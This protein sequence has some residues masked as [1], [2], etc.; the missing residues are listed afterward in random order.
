[1]SYEHEN[2]CRSGRPRTSGPA[3]VRRDVVEAEE[4]EDVLLRLEGGVHRHLGGA[5][6]D[7]LLA[8]LV[9]RLLVHV[10]PDWPGSGSVWFGSKPVRFGS[11]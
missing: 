11:I 2:T 10:A 4:A 9:L 8:Q 1:M 7:P 6:G 5:D 3:K